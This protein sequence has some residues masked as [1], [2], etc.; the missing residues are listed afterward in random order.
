MKEFFQIG[1]IPALLMAALLVYVVV[2]LARLSHGIRKRRAEDGRS[3]VILITEEQDVSVETVVTG[4]DAARG[5]LRRILRLACGC[6][7]DAELP[8]AVKEGLSEDGLSWSGTWLKGDEGKEETRS[9]T[10][11]A[12]RIE[13]IG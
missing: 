4:E 6:K 5:E 11:R 10:I 13:R 9:V 8:E 1:S 12:A 2:F 7:P 3:L